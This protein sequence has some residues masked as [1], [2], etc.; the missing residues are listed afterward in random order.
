MK[1]T[2]IQASL[3]CLYPTTKFEKNKAT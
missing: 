2:T 3:W 1:Y